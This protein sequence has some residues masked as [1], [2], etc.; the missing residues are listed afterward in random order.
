MMK[1]VDYVRL[2][3]AQP[4]R[5]RDELR[6]RQRL[7]AQHEHLAREE[8]ALDPGEGLRPERDRDVDI[9]GFQSKARAQRLELRHRRTPGRPPGSLLNSGCRPL[10][11]LRNSGR[12]SPGSHS[13]ICGQMISIA[14][15]RSIG[16]SMIMVSLRAY[17]RRTLAMAHEIMRQRP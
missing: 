4:A 1:L 8:R 13:G 12:M 11:Y 7:S 17:L 2:R 3:G 15:T 10:V 14:S 16:T 5:E 9:V 6:R